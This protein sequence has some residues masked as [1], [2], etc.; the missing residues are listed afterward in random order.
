MITRVTQRMMTGRELSQLG[1]ASTRMAD[2][3][4]QMTTGKKLSRPSDGPAD[5]TVALK[6]RAGVAQQTQFQRNAD[7][8]Q[9]WLQTIDSALQS[10]NTQVTRA[11]TLALQGANTA[12]NGQTAENALADEIDQI[13]Q[14]LLATANSQYLGRP[15]FGG[16][17]AGGSAFAQA[18]VTDS[19][20]NPVLDA[21]GNQVQQVQYVGD[22]GSV[23]RRVGPDTVV[24]VDSNGQSVFGSTSDGTSPS[25]SVFDAL[26]KLSTALRSSDQDGIQ[27]GIQAMQD[28]RTRISSAAADEGA[29]MNQITAASNVAG[30][31]KLAL[32]T[33]QSNVE[34]IDIAEATI[35]LE[36]Q[37]TAYNAALAAISK[38][39]QQSLLD[40]LA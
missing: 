3:Q 24:R 4:E 25:T 6:A 8:G 19:S 5:T 23:N 28:A 7:D 13:K 22:S 38:T 30:D 17:T 36:T 9:A 10:A 34:D 11:Y 21:D 15:V 39:S 26:D 32:Q 27:A 12:T 16:T 37:T 2:A 29:R 18:G 1:Q 14:G 31:N 20:G 35:N 40:Y 33:V